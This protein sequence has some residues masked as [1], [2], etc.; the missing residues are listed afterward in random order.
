MQEV[1]IKPNCG[2]ETTEGGAFVIMKEDK[3]E[4]VQVER[5]EKFIDTDGKV[6]V[7]LINVTRG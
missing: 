3:Q 4:R 2:W 7:K 6:K 5:S 1:V